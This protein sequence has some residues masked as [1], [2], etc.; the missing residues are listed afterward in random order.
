MK[1]MP[2]WKGYRKHKQDHN[3]LPCCIT[4]K[5]TTNLLGW[6]PE[7]PLTCTWSL[8]NLLWASFLSFKD[9]PAWYGRHEAPRPGAH[10]NNYDAK[11]GLEGNISTSLRSLYMYMCTYIMRNQF[12]LICIQETF[13]STWHIAGH[14]AEW[15][16][17]K[18]SF[19]MLK[20]FLKDQNCK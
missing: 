5:T 18:V 6:I 8:T 9:S 10:T 11:N 7:L 14:W 3:T 13:C 15:H 17:A 12:I 4:W 2:S 1:G 16:K 19:P 20:F